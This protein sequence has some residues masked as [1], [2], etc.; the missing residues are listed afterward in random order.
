MAPSK[1]KGLY[2]VV[3]NDKGVAFQNNY[4]NTNIANMLHYYITTTE[5]FSC[6]LSSQVNQEILEILE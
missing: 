4:A 2:R 5:L 3:S 1:F 6:M